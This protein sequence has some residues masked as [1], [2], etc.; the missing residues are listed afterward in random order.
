MLLYFRLGLLVT[1]ITFAAD[2]VSAAE[3]VTFNRDVLPILQ[4]NCQVCH[5][6]GEI[7]PMSFLTYQATRPWAK[8]I[9]AAVVSKTMPPWFADP[10]FGHFRNERRLTE[11]E[12]AMLAAWADG[13]APEGDAKDMPVPVQ[14]KEGWNIRPDLVFR[15]PEPLKIPAKGT[16]EYTYIA[17]AAPFKEDTWVGRRDSPVRPFARAPCHCDGP[18]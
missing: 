18:S 13:G 17:V 4:R 9:K 10:R 6:P 2:L 7:G 15:L 14:F 5:R 8:A 12:I 11:A 16:V 3:N 1:M